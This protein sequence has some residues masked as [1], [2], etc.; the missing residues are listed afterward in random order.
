[1]ARCAT[2]AF[3]GA[4]PWSC[5]RGARGRFGG[6]G[7][8]AG[9]RVSPASPFPPRVSRTVCG[10][11]SLPVVPYPRSLVRHSMR[12]VHSAGS[13]RLRF[14]YSP[15]VLCLCVRSRSRSVR[16]PPP[17]VGLSGAYNRDFAQ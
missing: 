13:V 4:V 17:S 2:T 10:G 9:F 16:P 5:V 11:L 1:M 3:A 6:V 8:G 7:A 14:W 12:F 15:R